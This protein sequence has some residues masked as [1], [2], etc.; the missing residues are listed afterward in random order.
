MNVYRFRVLL[1][2][3]DEDIFRDIDLLPSNNL[4][5]LHK[6]IQDAFE[7][8]DSQMASFYLSNDEWEKGEELTLFDMNEPGVEEA[9]RMMDEAVLDQTLAGE[10]DKLLYVFDFMNIWTF[11][12][13]LIQIIKASESVSYPAIISFV[14]KAPNQYSKGA[15]MQSAEAVLLT[16]LEQADQGDDDLPFQDDIFEGFDDFNEEY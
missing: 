15:A 9:I 12:V 3:D 8:D 16:A 2:H 7:F 4:Q 10:G 6:S 14:G 1:Q 11:H 5:D 13:E